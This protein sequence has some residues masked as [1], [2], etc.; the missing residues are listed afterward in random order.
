MADVMAISDD[1]SEDTSRGGW[2]GEK[3]DGKPVPNN[4]QAADHAIIGCGKY[5]PRDGYNSV[6]ITVTETGDLTIGAKKETLVVNDWTFFSDF[7]LYYVQPICYKLT[8]LVDNVV[9]RELD[10][11]CDRDLAA[12]MESLGIPTKEGYT[13]N[14][15]SEMPETMPAEDI[16]VVGSFTINS[17]KVIF[18]I[19]DEFF[20]EKVLEYGAAIEAPAAPEKEG[21]TFNGWGEVAETVPAEDV[22]YEGSY[23]VN[24]YK[25]S[26]YYDDDLVNTV[27]VEYGAVIPEYIYEASLNIVWK[28]KDEVQDYTTMPAKDIV[29]VGVLDTTGLD[30]LLIDSQAVIYDLSGRRVLEAVKGFYI[31]NGKKVLVK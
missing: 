27:E 9:Y 24:K 12:V 4:M 14:G 26:Y 5:V 22:V 2:S 20:E 29:Y 3:Y 11:P 7:S 13:F 15:W 25:V 10:V 17:Y 18:Q 6:D 28:I 16:E 8:L 1:P 30:R 31:I 23:T 19:G 21:H